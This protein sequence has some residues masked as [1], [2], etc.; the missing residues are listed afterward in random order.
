[1]QALGLIETRGLVVAI[2]S[3]DAM[4]KA[5]DVNLLEKIYVG[6]GLVLISQH[7]IAHPHEDLDNV[8][9]SVVPLKNVE[10]STVVPVKIEL[11]EKIKIIEEETVEVPMIMDLSELPNKESVDKMSLGYGLEAVIMVLSKLKVVQ[12]RNLAREYKNFGIAG[13]SVSK[14]N[15]KLLLMKFREYYVHN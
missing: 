9:L 3:L 6:G 13:R 15:K 14:A 8:I 12:L 5:A 10:M 7:V 1:M 4:L 2:E 11:E